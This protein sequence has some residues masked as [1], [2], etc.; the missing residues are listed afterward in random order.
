MRF[1]KA[2]RPRQLVMETLSSAGKPLAPPLREQ[3]ETRFGHDL[4]RVRVHDDDRAAR[5]ADAVQARAYTVGSHVVF[6]RGE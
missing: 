1:G 6:G 2:V 4:S 5:S 3:M